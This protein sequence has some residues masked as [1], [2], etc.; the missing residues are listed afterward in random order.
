MVMLDMAKL[1]CDNHGIY[2]CNELEDD[3]LA[4]LDEW[5]DPGLVL[6]P[7]RKIHAVTL[8]VDNYCV[9]YGNVRK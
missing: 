3:L 5:V 9:W 4:Y 8:D 2:V 1:W 7:L 6:E